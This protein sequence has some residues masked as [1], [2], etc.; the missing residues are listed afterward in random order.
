MRITAVAYVFNAEKIHEEK[1]YP[2]E[3]LNYGVIAVTKTAAVINSFLSVKICLCYIVD[4]N[5]EL[6]HYE[7]DFLRV[8]IALYKFK[9]YMKRP[10]QKTYPVR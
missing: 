4:I 2:P 5:I 8:Y 6:G 3:E 7:C 10:L 1:D 9:L